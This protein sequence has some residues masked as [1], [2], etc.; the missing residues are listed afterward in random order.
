MSTTSVA[1]RPTTSF[2]VAAAAALAIAAGA[3]V[4]SVADD[5]GR[6]TAPAHNP[7]QTH[8]QPTLPK[9]HHFDYTS[10]GGHVMTGL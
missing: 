4:V 10:S 9:G 8:D 7:A 3:V 1:H 5:P 6:P 2:L